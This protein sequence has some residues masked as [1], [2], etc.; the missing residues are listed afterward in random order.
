M[1]MSECSIIVAV[2]CGNRK[3]SEDASDIN[4]KN[5][6][7]LKIEADSDYAIEDIYDD[8]PDIADAFGI[9][10]NDLEAGIYRV[11][12]DLECNSMNDCK[13]SN[14]E[15]EPICWPECQ[16]ISS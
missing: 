6:V 9:I 12:F 13:A 8:T 2:E 7:I 14:I 16:R 1:I 10:I 4:F 3:L 15:I 11:S 5:S